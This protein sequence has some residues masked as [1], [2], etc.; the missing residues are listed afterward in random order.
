MMN[1]FEFNVYWA[2][3]LNGFCTGLGVVFANW[4]YNAFL[5][6][7]MNKMSRK[8]KILHKKYIQKKKGGLK[9]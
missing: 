8:A 3:A 1:M 4:F 9:K 5:K 6:T 2:L 7:H